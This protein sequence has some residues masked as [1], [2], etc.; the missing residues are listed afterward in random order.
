MI[1]RVVLPA[2]TRPQDQSQHTAAISTDENA[3]L[4]ANRERL[5]Q[6]VRELAAD[7]A[8]ARR[9]CRAKQ[10]RIDSLKAEDARLLAAAPA[11]MRRDDPAPEVTGVSD[12]GHK[13]GARRRAHEHTLEMTSSAVLVLRHGTLALKQENASLRHELASLREQQTGSTDGIG[14]RGRQPSSSADAVDT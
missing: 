12:G 14:R 13:L 10:Q 4:A 8:R 6:A 3:A 9:D 1:Q 5:A 11:V 7:L 2:S